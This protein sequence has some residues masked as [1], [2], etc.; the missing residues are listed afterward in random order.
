MSAAVAKVTRGVRVRQSARLPAPN[1]TG[2]NF[3]CLAP[4][5]DGR[6]R[7]IKQKQKENHSANEVTCGG[8]GG[9]AG[10]VTQ[11]T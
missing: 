3:S 4:R 8:V 2:L 11:G 9:Q 1:E 7:E 10:Q 5:H 6:R